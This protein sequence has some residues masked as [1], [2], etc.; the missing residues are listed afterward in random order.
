MW[1]LWYTYLYFWITQKRS[2]K[3]NCLKQ[4]I[5]KTK[6]IIIDTFLNNIWKANNFN[7]TYLR[8]SPTF[9]QIFFNYTHFFRLNRCRDRFIKYRIRSSRGVLKLAKFCFFCRALIQRLLKIMTSNKK[10][11]MV[12]SLVFNY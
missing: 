11:I 1:L 9:L 10:H 3:C 7:K 5:S 6:Y 2:S 12:W 4:C 8:T